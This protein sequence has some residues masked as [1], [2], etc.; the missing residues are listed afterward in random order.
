MIVLAPDSQLR[1]KKKS[2]MKSCSPTESGRS[3]SCPAKHIERKS[4]VRGPTF[5]QRWQEVVCAT[6][7]SKKVAGA[8]QEGFS[9]PDTRTTSPSHLGNK[10][11]LWA[12]HCSSAALRNATATVIVAPATFPPNPARETTTTILQRNSNKQYFFMRRQQQPHARTP[13]EK[14]LYGRCFSY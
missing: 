1:A 2:C 9:W 10:N 5:Q 12:T 14:E 13:K 11:A 3:K 4:C 8:H 6:R 7:L